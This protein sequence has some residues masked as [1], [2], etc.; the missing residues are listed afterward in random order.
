MGN[1]LASGMM[2]RISAKEVTEYYRHCG[3]PCVTTLGLHVYR[4][5]GILCLLFNSS[6]SCPPAV[7]LGNMMK[8]QLFM[9][10]ESQASW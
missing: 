9:A 4:P 8:S 5:Q 1:S 7:S 6:V 10:L 2:P 3:S